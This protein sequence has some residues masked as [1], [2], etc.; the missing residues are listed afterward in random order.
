MAIKLTPPVLR[1][2]LAPLA[3]PDYRRLLFSNFLWW[4][5]RWMEQIIVGWLVLELTDSAWQVAVI[6]FY[7]SVPFL[8]SGFFSG[9]LID[10]F[11]RRKIILLAQLTNFLVA[12]VL[13]LLLWTDRIAY[14]HLV[15]GALLGGTAWSL[16]W[17]ARR[18][19]VPDLVGKEKTVDA[20]LLESFMQNISRVLGPF[21]GGTLIAL[22]GATGG[23]TVLAAISGLAL[24]I[25][26]GI[27]NR[28]IPR[29]QESTT[30][31]WA[32][33]N[34]GLDYVRRNQTI[35]GVVLA[36][37]VMN[38]LV[39]PYMTLLPVFARDVLAQGPVGLGLLGTAS[40]VGAFLGLFLINH[41]R[42][43]ISTGWIFAAGS[44]FQAVVLVA[45][46]STGSFPVALALL[47]LSGIGQACFGTMQSAI[48]LL[49]A[50]DEMRSR[51]MGM[52]V[53]AI[54]ASPLGKL[55]LGAMAENFGAPL[56]VAGS[57]FLAAA[58][59]IAITA[60]LPGLRKQ[61][62]AAPP[63]LLPVK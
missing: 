27:S 37:I 59:M 53:L 10:R 61:A 22:L 50:S 28:P 43:Y 63:R 13:A 4:Q 6:G 48:I 9:D 20:M 38:F 15:A 19:F 14:W 58:M 3:L 46:A 26:L 33:I 60:A 55:Q 12:V 42:R 51:V 25:L 16:D 47:L 32:R 5:A 45:F 21:A 11:G 44:F 39:F 30:S 24:L 54:G 62:E 57:T 1:G 2:T 17:P 7:Q 23:Y 49:S 40:G 31:P 34:E 35:L 18:S 41:V 56:A 52:L 36:T 29:S 8:V